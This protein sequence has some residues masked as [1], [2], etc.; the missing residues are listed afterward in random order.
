[1]K[2]NIWNF[3]Y[4]RELNLIKKAEKVISEAVNNITQQLPYEIV[5]DDLRIS[6]NALGEIIG[7]EYDEDILDEIFSKFCVGK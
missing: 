4:F 6:Y 3:W 7:E 1:M 2:K 5:A